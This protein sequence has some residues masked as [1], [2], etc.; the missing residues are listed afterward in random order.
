VGSVY[1]S[2]QTFDDPMR[3]ISL[4]RSIFSHR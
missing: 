3:R 4:M 1:G 2:P